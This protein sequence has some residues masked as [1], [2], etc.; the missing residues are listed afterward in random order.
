MVKRAINLV[1]RERGG[2]HPPIACV[3]M[4][5]AEYLKHFAY[6]ENG[7]Y[8]GSEPQRVWTEKELK[9]EFGEYQDLPPRRWVKA[10]DGGRVF[11]VE[12]S[13]AW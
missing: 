3:Y 10:Q 8:I 6:D 11:M 9:I 2:P 7:W 12:E 13:E 1:A 4:P 5:R